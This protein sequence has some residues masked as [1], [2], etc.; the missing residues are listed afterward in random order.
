MSKN[1]QIGSFRIGAELKRVLPAK[2]Y[3]DIFNGDVS[4]NDAA[5]ISVDRGMTSS[6]FLNNGAFGRAYDAVQNVA[7]ELRRFAESNTDIFYD[8]VSFISI[9]SFS[10]Q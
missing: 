4:Q 9:M 3:D 10:A 8:Q 2:L 1:V 6:A 5:K 7:N